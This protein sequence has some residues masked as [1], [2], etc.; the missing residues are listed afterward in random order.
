MALVL[1]CAYWNMVHNKV[2][3]KSFRSPRIFTFLTG[4]CIFETY[5]VQNK[6]LNSAIVF[7]LS[8]NE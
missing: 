2:V 3:A 6:S 5:L 4:M 1:H 7:E 8:C